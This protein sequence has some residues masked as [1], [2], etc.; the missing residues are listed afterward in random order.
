MNARIESPLYV[1]HT[2]HDYARML[3]LRDRAGDR[4]RADE[5]LE[6]ALATADERG[7][8]ALADRARPLADRPAGGAARRPPH[9]HR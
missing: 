5:L 9:S 4:E 1:A 6:A 2:Q 8:A 7:L 3:L